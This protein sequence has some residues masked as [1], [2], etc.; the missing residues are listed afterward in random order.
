V[1]SSPALAAKPS[2][3]RSCGRFKVV[4]WPVDKVRV[5]NVTCSRAKQM[6]VHYHETGHGLGCLTFDENAPIRIRCKRHVAVTR[7][8]SGR[9]RRVF[10]VAVINF[11]LPYCSAP[12]D[13]GI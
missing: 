10:V 13:C 7:V 8:Q 4:G 11:S 2:A 9:A 5:T 1:A 3:T 12:G 6:L